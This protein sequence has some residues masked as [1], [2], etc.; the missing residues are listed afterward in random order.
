MVQ[1]LLT[2]GAAVD[3]K[4]KVSVLLPMGIFF[5]GGGEGGA[6]HGVSVWSH[7]GAAISHSC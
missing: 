2:A 5:L 6:L 7:T 1:K 3:K 4:N